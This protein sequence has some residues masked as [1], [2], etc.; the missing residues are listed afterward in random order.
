MGRAKAEA[1]AYLEAKTGLETFE[2]EAWLASMQR[3]DW[4]RLRL[5]L[6]L[7]RGKDRTGDV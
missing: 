4:R 7:P 5:R 1:L 3:R 6:G 2:A